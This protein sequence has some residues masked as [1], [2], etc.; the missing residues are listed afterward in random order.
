M[1]DPHV[2][3]LNYRITH[4]KHFNYDDAE[5][6]E[7]NTSPDFCLKVK[8]KKV[9]FELKKHYATEDDAKASL[10]DFVRQWEFEACLEYGPDSFGLTYDDY[11]IIDRNPPTTKPDVDVIQIHERISV[12]DN[13][14]ITTRMLKFPSPPSDVSVNADDPDTNTMFERLMN[15]QRGKE[16]V[17]SMANFCLTVIEGLFD[18]G[19]RKKAA[20]H[21]KI[22]LD[23]LKRIGDLCANKGGPL[24]ARKRTGIRNDLTTEER[25]W[26][27]K[28]V[29]EI[30]CRVAKKAHN[31]KNRGNSF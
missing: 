19:K 12:S 6:F 9:R 26:L 1:N 29:K 17:T 2:V 10:K 13:L 28:S 24:G 14:E 15:C 18:R 23:T 4:G 20:S 5:E 21:F 25:E 31:S 11:E 8:D 3:A 16:P 22:N 30:I 27:V 7:D